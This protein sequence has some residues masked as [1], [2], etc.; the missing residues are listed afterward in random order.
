MQNKI[1]KFHHPEF[2]Q[3]VRER[4]GIHD[5]DITAEDALQVT[6]LYLGNFTF[7][8]EDVETLYCFSNLK[9]LDIEMREKNMRFWK[10]FSKLEDLCWVVWGS[11]VDFEVFGHMH[12]LS[13]LTVSGGVYSN[14]PFKNLEAL[15]PLK[16]LESLELHEFGAVDIAP[17]GRMTQ[18][19][20]F[21]L[22]YSNEVK[23]IETIGEM[24]W[25]EHLNMDGLY[26]DNLDFLDNLP[27]HVELD[28]CGIE[29]Y[30]NPNVDVQKWK[31]FQNADICEIAVKDPYW[32]YIY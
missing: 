4:T 3:E 21:Y 10:H 13:A 2:E 12:E 16:K 25:L 22:R 9:E 19:K 5:R 23:N 15:L 31:R 27:D 20:S 7:E 28:M 26:V 24:R 17:L 18:L 1:L 14:I 8:D 30:G 6:Q 11:C 29:I 32:R